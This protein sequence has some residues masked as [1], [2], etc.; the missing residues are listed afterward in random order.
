MSVTDTD[1]YS[2]DYFVGRSKPN[3]SIEVA[4]GYRIKGRGKYKLSDDIRCSSYGMKLLFDKMGS[5]KINKDNTPTIREMIE[6][7]F[8]EAYK[9]MIEISINY[10]SDEIKESLEIIPNQIVF[11]Y[12]REVTAVNIRDNNILNIPSEKWVVR[13][14]IHE[15][16]SELDG[17]FSILTLIKVMVILIGFIVSPH[18]TLFLVLSILFV[19]A[20]VH[21]FD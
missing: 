17:D 12:V 18:F 20:M 8:G 9:K 13:R 4:Y 16:A 7:S 21:V 1:I 5:M 10:F 14:F 6:D 15:L 2:R 3:I 11:D 19:Y